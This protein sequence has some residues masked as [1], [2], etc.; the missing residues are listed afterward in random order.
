MLR[1]IKLLVSVNRVVSDDVSALS[2]WFMAQGD[3][4]D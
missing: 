3:S 4:K 2:R 1:C